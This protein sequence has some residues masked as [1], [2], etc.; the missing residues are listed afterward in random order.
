MS[1]HAKLPSNYPD[2]FSQL[3]G[4]DEL[5]EPGVADLVSDARE[6]AWGMSTTLN[7][8]LEKLSTSPYESTF[9]DMPQADGAI[10]VAITPPEAMLDTMSGP[11]WRVIINEKHHVYKDG[12]PK[13]KWDIMDILV[14]LDDL[15]VAVNKATLLY[16]VGYGE[17][18]PPPG[19]PPRIV[20]DLDTSRYSISSAQGYNIKLPDAPVGMPIGMSWVCLKRYQN[21]SRTAGTALDIFSKLSEVTKVEAA[22]HLEQNGEL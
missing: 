17:A 10:R 6:T 4:L 2:V 11:K 22:P 16:V 19:I 5:V 9:Y 12:K 1:E 13:E 7:D 14:K 8:R 3:M 21:F 15:R 20:R 18:G